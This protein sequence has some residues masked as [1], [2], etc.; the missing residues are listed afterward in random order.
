MRV[1]LR[2]CTNKQRA[3]YQCYISHVDNVPE[4]QTEG[5]ANFEE[6]KKEKCCWRVKKHDRSKKTFGTQFVLRSQTQGERYRGKGDN[7]NNFSSWQV[8]SGKCTCQLAKSGKDEVKTREFLFIYLSI[9]CVSEIYLGSL[10]RICAFYH[11]SPLSYIFVRTGFVE[12]PFIPVL[13]FD[14]AEFLFNHETNNQNCSKNINFTEFLCTFEIDKQKIRRFD[15][16]F[17]GDG[18][19]KIHLYFLRNRILPGEKTMLQC[20]IATHVFI[21]LPLLIF[22]YH[23]YKT[24]AFFFF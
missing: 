1:F 8:F 9:F 13:D 5:V 6:K 21:P 19:S 11:S 18:G 23:R 14:W 24:F 3:H 7:P 15:D 22:K 17:R 20:S 10:I 12:T 2:T 16:L 4:W